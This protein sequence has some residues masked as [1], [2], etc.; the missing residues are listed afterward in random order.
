MIVKSCKLSN[1]YNKKLEV[2]LKN[3]VLTLQRIC[4]HNSIKNILVKEKF[5]C[6]LNT[7]SVKL[8][9]NYMAVHFG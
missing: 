6:S 7:E 8:F 2:F 9:I 3:R 1:E 4:F 5:R